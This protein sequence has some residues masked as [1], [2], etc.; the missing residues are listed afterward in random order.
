MGVLD[1]LIRSKGPTTSAAPAPAVLVEPEPGAG[2]LPVFA[3]FDCE[4]TGLVPAAD[5]V[6]ELS[7]VRC[8]A[9]GRTLDQW[10][11]RFD[12][13]GPVGATE[14][15]GIT[16]DDVAG[17]PLFRDLVH[18][19]TSRFAGL[20]PVAHNARF[21]LAFLRSEY[22]RAGWT[23]PGLPT[24][25]TLQESRMFLPDLGRRRLPDC[26]AAFGIA[27]QGAHSALGDALAAAGLLESYV[28]HHPLGPAGYAGVYQEARAVQWS[29]APS[30]AAFV[31]ARPR[32]APV[33]I[34]AVPPR[35]TRPLVQLLDDLVLA[36]AIGPDAPEGTEAYLE[37]LAEVLEDGEISEH[38]AAALADVAALY[39]LH[40]AVLADV[41]RTFVLALA[42]LA[43]E[44]G[45][46][47]RTERSELY[48]VADELGVDG[49]A[50][51]RSLEAA[52]EARFRR[53]SLGL[54]ALPDDWPHPIVLRV[55][56]SVVFTGCDDDI[57][58]LLE[59]R[60]AKAG[61]RVA[62][63][64][65][66]RTV[67]LVTDGS[68][69]GTKLAAARERGTRIIAPSVFDDLLTHVQP[70][71][72]Q[73]SPE[74]LQTDLTPTPARHRAHSPTP[75][76]SQPVGVPPAMVRA[77]ARANGFVVGERGRLP[78]EVFDAFA[79]ARAVDD[80]SPTFS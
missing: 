9:W 56:D 7:V 68:F 1:W 54:A 33:R 5:R 28:A 70:F 52:A 18:E 37:L 11:S 20:V 69:A 42:H 16:Q 45:V 2:R 76:A 65:S 61:V 12:P 59:A 67:A 34:R 72:G 46:I 41:H 40:D 6:I 14:I 43:V 15:H 63:A 62:S 19:V 13:E 74:R 31:G 10:V 38:E 3:V 48:D 49:R 36:D 30:G 73:A 71:V 4:T 66:A 39:E 57:R 22:L 8:D 58:D 17:A 75:T 35:E 27:H 53:L 26:C 25:C 24:L 23:L 77:W 78:R 55:G 79:A 60:A 47:T 44:D 64:I 50:V 51:V 21:D 29:S 80:S 32:R